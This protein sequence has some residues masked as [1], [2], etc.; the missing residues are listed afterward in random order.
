MDEDKNHWAYLNILARLFGFMSLITGL[1]FAVWGIA[2]IVNPKLLPGNEY[3]LTGSVTIEFLFIAVFCLVL[4]LCF[5][6][7]KPRKQNIE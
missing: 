5:L 3:S 6:L 2:F 7:V 4:G 1:G